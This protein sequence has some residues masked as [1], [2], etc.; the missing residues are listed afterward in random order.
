MRE[1]KVI[2]GGANERCCEGRCHAGAECGADD[3]CFACGGEGMA[4]CSAEPSCSPGA[5]CRADQLC[6]ACGGEGQGCCAGQT[7]GGALRCDQARCIVPC[8]DGCAPQERRCSSNGGVDVCGYDASPPC[9]LWRT[10]LDRCEDGD[11]CERGTC[12][13]RCPDD[14]EPSVLPTCVADLPMR[15][16]YNAATSCG[17][18]HLA[19]VS[20]DD[21]S[22]LSPACGPGFCWELPSP[23]GMGLKAITG[24]SARDLLLLDEQQDILRRDGDAWSYERLAGTGYPTAIAACDP[25]LHTAIAVGSGVLWRSQDRWTSEVVP[26][27][28]NGVYHAVAC[29]AAGVAVAVGEDGLIGVRDA[30]GF[31]RRQEANS[32]A[33]LRGVALGPG[34]DEAWVAGAQGTLLHCTELTSP[35]AGG[36]AVEAA[37]LTTRDLNAVFSGAAGVWAAGDAGVIL[38][39]DASGSWRRVAQGTVGSRLLAMKGLDDGTVWCAGEDGTFVRRSSG[40]WVSDTFAPAQTEFTGIFAADATHLYLVTRT[41]GIWLNDRGGQPDSAT[42]SRWR[43]IGGR[44]SSMSLHA[45]SGKSGDDVWTVGEKGAI[46]HRS[47]SRWSQIACEATDKDLW[48]VAEHPRGEEVYVVGDGGLIALVRPEGL[49]VQGAGVTGVSLRGVASFKREDWVTVA[50]GEGGTWLERAETSNWR[51]MLA[52]TSFDL[53]GVVGTPQDGAWAVGDHCTLLHRTDVFESI[54]VEG[55]S[56]VALRAVWRGEDGELFLGGDAGWVWHRSADP[57]VW[58]SHQLPCGSSPVRALVMGNRMRAACDAHGLFERNADGTWSPVQGVVSGS[59]VR[60]GWAS[61]EGTTFLVG[62]GGFV[63][64]LLN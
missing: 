19:P 24:W 36:C 3:R 45:I 20:E 27:D 5:E 14:C 7:C 48:A 13:P 44:P 50:V 41:G 59:F 8:G 10:E 64:R 49:V 51:T 39:R 56:G 28:E 1:T 61:P 6:Y 52:P 54:A 18:L 30:Q 42:E 21:P 37:G 12:T 29:T 26:G 53:H 23:Q 55:C 11:V 40:R 16:I 35:A 2:C 43:Q 34:G 32:S 62:E 60:G 4:C 38:E 47:Q 17:E 9:T 46:F 25:T 57:G 31:W 15:C 58:E 63:W 33:S 22:C